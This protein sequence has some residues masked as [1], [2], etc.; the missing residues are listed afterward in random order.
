MLGQG[1]PQIVAPPPRLTGQY[2]RV[3][4]LDK[5]DA[6]PWRWRLAEVEFENPDSIDAAYGVAA[7]ADVDG[8]GKLDIVFGG[9][10]SGPAVA[11][12]KGNGK[13]LVQARGLPR[14]MTLR[15]LDPVDLNGDGRV[16][17]LAISDVG[18]WSDSGGQPQAGGQ[19]TCAATTSGRS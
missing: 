1:R 3:F 11:L 6:G 14:A 15:A 2:L 18:E 7:V 9:H 16:D 17:L 8:D 4:R 13:F 12:N 19:T 10:G 5:D